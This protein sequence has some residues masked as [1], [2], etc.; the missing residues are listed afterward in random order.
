MRS[1]N[2]IFNNFY[3]INEFKNIYLKKNDSEK[4]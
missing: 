2:S 3:D 1:N 4:T